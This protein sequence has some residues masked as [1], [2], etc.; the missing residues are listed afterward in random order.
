MDGLSGQDARRRAQLINGVRDSY[1]N[2][3]PP[4]LLMLDHEEIAA[5]LAVVDERDRLVAQAC[6]EPDEVRS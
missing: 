4:F 3:T 1:T 2:T 6:A 5:L